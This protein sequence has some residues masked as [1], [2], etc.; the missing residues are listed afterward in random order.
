LN[1]RY[2]IHPSLQFRRVPFRSAR[3]TRHGRAAPIGADH[4]LGA[5]QSMRAKL[6][7][8]ADGRGS[9]VARLARVSGRV[10]PHNR[11]YYFAYWRGIEP[12]TT[13]ARLWFLDPDG[14]AA[15]PNED[16]LT[17]VVAA[18]HRSRLREFRMEPESAYRRMVAAL[19]DGPD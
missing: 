6:V 18:P 2:E 3:E 14:A 16:D 9:T 8:G 12:R 19:P 13:N 11:F 17:V 10:R 1:T 5:A 7:V 4:E 15:F